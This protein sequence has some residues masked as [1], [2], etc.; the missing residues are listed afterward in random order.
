MIEVKQLT[1]SE[2]I[3]QQVAKKFIQHINVKRFPNIYD[4]GSGPGNQAVVFFNLGFNVT[5]V[6][7][8]K[9]NYTQLKWISPD[10]VSYN[11]KKLNAIW[12]HHCLEHIRNPIDML[13]HWKNLLP[14]EGMLFITV[15]QINDIISSG[16]INGYTL[17]LLIYHLAI[18]GFDCSDIK[19]TKCNS[20][21]K[22]AVHKRPNIP[23]NVTSLTQ[24]ANSNIFNEDITKEIQETTRFTNNSINKTHWYD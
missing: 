9:P 11:N 6:D 14:K 18:A 4:V 17:P 8:I 15:P 5:C 3:Q 12:T 10:D 1:N 20:H 7:Y 24:L 22:V 16:H 23:T 2:L 21:L 13:I 19:Y